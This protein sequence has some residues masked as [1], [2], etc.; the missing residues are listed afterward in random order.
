MVLLMIPPSGIVSIYLL[1]ATT[2]IM[3]M[4]LAWAWG[5]IA[6]KAAFA[7]RPAAD[8]QAR[9]ASL[10]QAA[11]AQ[12][13]ATGIT[14]TAAAQVLIYEGYMLDAR[15]TVVIYCLVCLFIYL[16]VSETNPEN[17]TIDESVQVCN[18]LTILG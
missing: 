16:L 18:I 8:T 13:N 15:V 6:M 3:G 14:P 5:V 9:F 10:Q 17:N 2:M 7:A 1:G 11:A 12:A 4:L